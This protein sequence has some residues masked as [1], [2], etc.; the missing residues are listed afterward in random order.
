MSSLGRG[1]E[2]EE[3]GV[4]GTSVINQT[5]VPGRFPEQGIRESYVRH[6]H[7][8]TRLRYQ[9]DPEPGPDEVQ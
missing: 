6:C 8:A 7:L 1:D 2:L 9:S 4:R 5:Y 3:Q